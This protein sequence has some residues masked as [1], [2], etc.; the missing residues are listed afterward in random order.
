MNI[1]L[2]LGFYIKISTSEFLD[3]FWVKNKKI[4]VFCGLLT[5]NTANL[6]AEEKNK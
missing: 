5:V 6:N 3:V 1:T 4:V 2:T